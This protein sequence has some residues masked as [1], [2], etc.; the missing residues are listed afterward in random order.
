[1]T[2]PSPV[3]QHPHGTT[4]FTGRVP[5]L[6]KVQWPCSE[7][8]LPN[9]A[10]QSYLVGT[11]YGLQLFQ[12]GFTPYWIRSHPDI[13]PGTNDDLFDAKSSDPIILAASSIPGEP[14][15]GVQAGPV[16]VLTG[17][18]IRQ[19]G[20]ALPKVSDQMR[21]HASIHLG[22]HH[23]KSSQTW[24]THP[25]STCWPLTLSSFKPA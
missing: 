22:V 18:T 6:D 10:V 4:S 19:R 25:A 13:R 7:M 20:G 16:D 2:Q 23:L 12:F 24:S 9:R 15:G 1:M 17:S 14:P 5:G 3:S 21:K 8:P 11:E